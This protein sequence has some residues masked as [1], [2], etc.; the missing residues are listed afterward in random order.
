MPTDPVK[1]TGSF[2]P[3]SF[4]NKQLYL[5]ASS[6]KEDK[7]RATKL[8]AEMAELDLV[9]S[10]LRKALLHCEGRAR[11]LIAESQALRASNG[12]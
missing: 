4:F 3:G 6:S 2:T 9:L 1:F 5:T 12:V 8:I 7:A 11:R 10:S